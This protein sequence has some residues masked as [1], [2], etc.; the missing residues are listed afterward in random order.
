MVPSSNSL[1]MVMESPFHFDNLEAS[2]PTFVKAV[3]RLSHASCKPVPRSVLIKLSS[4]LSTSAFRVMLPFSA[5]SVTP[6]GLDPA[7]SDCNSTVASFFILLTN[8]AAPTPTFDWPCG[9]FICPVT[10]WEKDFILVLART[11]TPSSASLFPPAFRS[12]PGAM[13]TLA[14]LMLSNTATP[15]P[16]ET[17]SNAVSNAFSSPCS[18]PP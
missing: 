16:T 4:S 12:T 11:V 8:T 13:V 9:L 3:I 7:V 10:V 15:A 14:V 6:F 5:A 1:C 17:Y 2:P 18:L